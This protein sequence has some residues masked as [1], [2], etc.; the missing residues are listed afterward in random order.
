MTAIS[1]Y[2]QIDAHRKRIEELKIAIAKIS[3]L[4]PDAVLTPPSA[5]QFDKPGK[6]NPPSAELNGG[7]LSGDHYYRVRVDAPI[8]D[9][10]DP[11]TAEC[12][13]IIEALNMTFNEGEAFKALWRLAASRQGRGKPGSKAQYDADKIAHYGA[14]VAAQTRKQNA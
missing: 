4:P 5:D 7:T 13:D 8:S 6:I 11:Y 1:L 12:S 3:G 9:E 14:R 2:A 10:V